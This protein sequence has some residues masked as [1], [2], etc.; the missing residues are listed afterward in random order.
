[1]KKYIFIIFC[2]C[3][4]APFG[5]YADNS[6][7][8]SIL[9]MDLQIGDTH[10]DHTPNAPHVQPGT[11]GSLLQI[12]FQPEDKKEDGFVIDNP[13]HLDNCSMEELIRLSK[14]V[15]NK[16]NKRVNYKIPFN[17]DRIKFLP[18]IPSNMHLLGEF[19]TRG[20]FDQNTTGLQAALMVEAK[21]KT[22][23]RYG[24]FKIKYKSR[25]TKYGFG[26]GGGVAKY[27][28]NEAAGSGGGVTGY[29]STENFKIPVPVFQAYG[30]VKIP[31]EKKPEK[32]KLID[33]TKM[34]T[35]EQI[36]KKKIRPIC[37]S[38]FFA[39]NEDIPLPGQEAKFEK[40]GLW[41]KNN[42]DIILK[43]ISRGYCDERGDEHYN[44]GLGLR[45][46][47]NTMYM[48]MA[49]A[50]SLCGTEKEKIAFMKKISQKFRATSASNLDPDFKAEN[51]LSKKK[52]HQL[53]RRVDLILNGQNLTAP[54]IGGK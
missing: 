42:P 43:S 53:N 5:A 19:D 54:I 21:L 10:Q 22:N 37:K 46:G 50:A 2:C 17:N 4:L 23:C 18:G 29:T 3:L 15:R 12:F 33:L 39:F 49:Y 26:L 16:Y 31:I 9:E 14:G 30:G 27:I 25:P 1:M 45:R 7:M 34:P 36:A 38:I 13:K 35:M 44:S 20:K 48:S 11:S 40:I 52:A 41:I 8:T 47:K 51:G 32:Q 24:L 6:E 28:G